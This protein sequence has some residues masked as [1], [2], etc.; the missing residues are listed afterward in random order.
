[1]NGF[2][3]LKEQVKDQKDVALRQVVD[4]LLS[5]DDL[6]QSFLKEDKTLEGMCSFIRKRGTACLQ[7]G[8][9]FITNEVVY[10]WAVMYFT[11]PNKYLKIDTPKSSNKNTSTNKE[12]STKNN[13]VSIE[14]AKKA[15]EEK[16]QVEQLTLFGGAS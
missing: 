1:M 10:A 9:N 16:K 5:R 2:D 3:R 15:I 6:E 14:T 13:V 12:T 4:V 11:L 8:W 7:N